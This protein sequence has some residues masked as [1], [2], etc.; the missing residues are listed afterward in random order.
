MKR[1]VYVATSATGTKAVFVLE[2]RDDHVPGAAAT[3]P[4]LSRPRFDPGGLEA[5]LLRNGQVTRH[6]CILLTSNPT[7]KHR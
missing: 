4:W 3:R 2:K 5:H 1:S 6:E 7:T